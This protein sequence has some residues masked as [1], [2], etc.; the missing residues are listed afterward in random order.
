M[1]MAYSLLQ[2]FQPRVRHRAKL[3]ECGLLIGVEG[4]EAVSLL[5]RSR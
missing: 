3:G 5:R 1:P 4:A 2:L